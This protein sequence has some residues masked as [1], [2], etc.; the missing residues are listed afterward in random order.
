MD[1]TSS[2]KSTISLRQFFSIS[3]KSGLTSLFFHLFF[4]A[5]YR[6]KCQIAVCFAKLPIGFV[7]L[8]N[9]VDQ[10]RF[11]E[12]C[13][14]QIPPQG[15]G[16]PLRPKLIQTEIAAQKMQA[17]ASLMYSFICKKLKIGNRVWGKS[18]S[19]ICCSSDSIKDFQI[20][21]RTSLR[22]RKQA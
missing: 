20:F 14:H 18:S 4:Q 7:P 17:N 8:Q 3:S 15:S 2:L 6:N 5:I 1:S 11:A 19:F 21:R 16:P 12:G 10:P 13:Q 22:E 9:F